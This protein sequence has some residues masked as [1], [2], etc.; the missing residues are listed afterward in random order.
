MKIAVIGA[1]N[2]GA[3][4]AMRIAESSLADVVMV[5]VKKEIASAKSLDMSDAASL[6]GHESKISGTGSYELI[7]DSSI[8]IITAGFPRIPGMSRE[9]LLLKNKQ[10]IEEA[11]NSIKRYADEAIVIVVTNP[12][13]IM[14]YITYK[15]CGFPKS[16]VFGMAGDLDSA[17]FIE[18]IS[19]KL[20]VKRTSIQ[21]LVLGSHGDTMVPVISQ[22]KVKGKP[23]E[24]VLTRKDIDDLIA[25]TKTRGSEIVSLLGQG[26]AYY[27]PSAAA[28]NLVKSVVKN[29]KKI[30][31]V[32]ALLEGEYGF[33]NIYLGVPAKIGKKG[34][35]G[36]IEINLTQ[37]EK[38]ALT[39]SAEEVKNNLS[40]I[41]G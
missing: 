18:L 14:S 40:K 12:L 28:F 2:V 4:L 1:G 26:S 37:S 39:R 6:I 24:K 19:E 15:T 38:A 31:C 25:K 35:E 21:T 20:N 32:S 30:H 5:D 34:I 8:V 22:T 7:K 41:Y 9:D 3:T 27:A 10:V 36:I 11:G 23:I 17:R 16:R 13:D 33:Q 29:S